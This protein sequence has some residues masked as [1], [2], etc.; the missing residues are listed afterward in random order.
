[1]NQSTLVGVMITLIVIFLPAC[2]GIQMTPSPDQL[3]TLPVE[4][5]LPVPIST[6]S[7]EH[8]SQPETSLQIE[9]TS[10]I[11][12][13]QAAE[14]DSL[15]LY[16]TSMVDKRSIHHLAYEKLITNE[17]GRYRAQ[18]IVKI[19][20]LAD[21]D[22][23]ILPVTVESGDKVVNHFGEVV[24]LDKGI[25]LMGI[26]GEK[27]I[28]DG[29]PAVL[30]QMIV[31]FTLQELTWSDGRPVSAADSVYSFEVNRD[32]VLPFTTVNI[33]RLERT[34]SYKATGDLTLR[35]T[36]L[37]GWRDPL[38]FLNVWPPLPKHHLGDIPLN[39]LAD[40]PAAARTPLS[41]GPFAVTEWQP[42]G[43]I[44]L[45]PNPFYDRTEEQDLNVEGI[46][47]RSINDPDQAAAALR[48][49]RCSLLA[50]SL[51]H[52]DLATKLL[53][54]GFHIMTIA[55]G[56]FEH[57]SLAVNSLDQNRPRWFE[58]PRVRQA[59]TL[60]TDRQR[61]IHEAMGGWADVWDSYVSPHHIL[62]PT[63]RTLLAYDPAAGNA[64]LDSAGY[65]DTNGNGIRN[66]PE[67]G[68]PLT[69]SIITTSQSDVRPH[70]VSVIA[71]NWAACGIKVDPQA[72]SPQE[73]F[74]PGPDGPVF[75]R[76][77]DASLFSLGSDGE[78]PCHHW[79]IDQ[80]PNQDDRNGS[81]VTGWSNTEFDAAC[82]RG[83]TAFW[84]SADYR[85]AHQEAL[86]IWDKERPG[87]P[88]FGYVTFI[89]IRPDLD[90]MET[91]IELILKRL[92]LN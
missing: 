39:N 55:S 10:E 74:L 7:V 22:A 77:F 14:P 60:C 51:V 78:P 21:G 43:D 88:L 26:N 84:G 85:A 35:W 63:E 38:Y 19:P 64:L 11:V 47:F 36:G 86:R 52:I 70:I 28:F 44:R 81:N 29:Q 27:I 12:V 72:I 49:G 82:R 40:H 6:P 18:G 15:F 45:E 5:T 61:I 65:I 4:A 71:E 83:Q 20:D 62:L 30:P 42:G 75:G 41:N 69:P 3:P 8:R 79:T 33:N 32:V 31:D 48:D 25:E 87:I 34:D 2:K 9:T 46:V 1:M 17:G 80:I 53:A 59:L 24:I 23:Q 90:A 37:P 56:A 91:D 57:L 13:C 68:L 66:H 89:A 67:S 73:M 54:E 92:T 16:G 76:R 50:Q 58:D